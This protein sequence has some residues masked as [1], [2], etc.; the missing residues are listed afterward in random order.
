MAEQSIVK[1]R[2]MKQQHESPQGVLNS[3]NSEKN[4]HLVRSEPS[5]AVARI[6]ETFWRVDWDLGDSSPHTQQNIPD[7]CI[8]MVFEQSSA[9]IVGAVTKRYTAELGGKGYIY[10]IKFRPGGF[11]ALT[12]LHVSDFTDSKL[13]ISDIFKPDGKQLVDDIRQAKTVEQMQLISETF[14]QAKLPESFDDIT[15]LE[16]IIHEIYSNPAI[17]KVSDLSERFAI[18]KRGLQRLF[19]CQVGVSPKWAIRKC[20]IQEV[21]SQLEAGSHDWQQLVLELGYFDQSHF[22]KD[23]TSLI[24]VTPTQYI[25]QLN[26]PA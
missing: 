15:K 25:K 2:H 19:K 21:L 6:V 8:H 23:F 24:G 5:K 1:T 12:Q 18:S 7:P 11:H 14:L 9:Y 17:M 26:E 16:T 4:Y 3:R 20:R 10:G 22:I 13:R